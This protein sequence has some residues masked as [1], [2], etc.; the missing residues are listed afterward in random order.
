MPAKALS[1]HLS[2]GEISKK[3]VEFLEYLEVER[4]SSPL[5]IRNYRHYLDRF[6]LWAQTEGKISSLNQIDSDNVDNF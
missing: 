1:P 3:T 4:G 5:T 2:R 6:L